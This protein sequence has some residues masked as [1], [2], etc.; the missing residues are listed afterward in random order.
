MTTYTSRHAK[1]PS[2]RRSS[3]APFYAL[4]WTGVGLII[5]VAAVFGGMVVAAAV[6]AIRGAT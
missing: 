1:Q 3:V 2:K 5:L 4:L 6:M